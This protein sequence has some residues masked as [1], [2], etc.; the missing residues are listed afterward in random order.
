[1]NIPETQRDLLAYLDRITREIGSSAG[2]RNAIRQE[3]YTTA[4]IAES[5]AVSRNLAS[6]Y[7][8]ELVR[9]GLV[10]KAG[11]R[12][13]HYFHRRALERYFQAKIER[14]AY[15]S[16]SELFS[17]QGRADLLDFS[18][19]IGHEL[20]LSSCIDQLRAAMK[21]PPHGLPVLLLGAPGTGKAMLA[22]LMLEYGRNTGILHP[23]AKLVT[24]DCSRYQNDIHG[25]ADTYRMQGGWAER[26]SGG[27]LYFKD[28]YLLTPSAQELVLNWTEREAGMQRMSQAQAPELPRFVLSTSRDASDATTRA[29]ARRIPMVATV[30]S[31]RDRSQE[32]REELTLHF[33]KEEG[34]RMG[35]DILIS[36]G[37]FRCLASASFE[38]NVRGLRSCVT[39]CCAEAYLE[40]TADKL[41]IRTYQLP[42]EIL[43]ASPLDDQDEADTQ[44]IDTTRSIESQVDDRAA[45][46]LDTMLTSYEGYRA[47]ELDPCSCVAQLLERVRDLEDYLAF[48]QAPTHSKSAAYEHIADSIVSDINDLY[49][50]DLSRKSSH[51]IAQSICL[52]LWPPTSLS[53][54]IS[55]HG[56][57]LV[58][59]LELVAQRRRF[60]AT[61]A[62]RLHEELG[63]VLG[64]E[65]GD[66][67]RLLV[68]AHVSLTQD[69]SRRRR[70]VGIIL[71][72]GYSTATSIADA[73]NR[74]L[75][76]RVFEAI[77]MPYDQRVKDVVGPL[78][79]IIDRFS[80]VDELA[81]LVDMGSL[82]DI[83]KSLGAASS[84]TLGII[85]N[86]STGLAVEVGAGLIDGQPVTQ[87]L[88]KAAEFC[89]CSFHVIERATRQEAIVFCA[90]GGIEASEKI[91]A[92]VAQS[93]EAELPVR[94]V[95][96]EYRQLLN[97][98][99]EDSTFAT[100]DVRA[101]IGTDD[102]HVSGIPFI[103]LE[104]LI[105]GEGAAQLDRAFA[106]LLDAGAL[107]ALHQNLIKNMTLRNVVESITILNPDKLFGEIERAVDRLQQLTGDA[108]SGRVAI[109]L[110]VHLCC[111]VERLVTRSP[112]DSY[113]DENR[114]ATE[115]REFITAFRESF[116]GISAHYRV[117][118]PV[119]EIAYAYDYINSRHAP[120]KHANSGN[121][122][123][124]QQDE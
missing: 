30:P 26:C 97:N 105:S 51:L 112:I 114:F 86:A 14:S 101:I 69:L 113:A 31:L 39:N 117:E 27:V 41:T 52:Q 87:I 17:R 73:A 6:Q 40:R 121:G 36:R 78:Q 72:H 118:A 49:S 23:E 89:T 84:I 47:G 75:H 59:M 119:T 50:I 10:V 53:R 7:L 111:L 88:A 83:Y 79:Q 122:S 103:A 65:L 35:T 8:N 116:S 68:L 25:F 34:R 74:I 110:Y 66:L 18:Q 90:E 124:A 61:V 15:P 2:H 28:A 107:K 12:P 77:D 57:E 20:S 9:A 115:H 45:G 123:Q 32:E 29:L 91:K 63:R 21:Y 108:I 85:N 55:A 58:A 62:A 71:S 48:N 82:Q 43:S 104:D 93:L 109:G 5:L 37:A 95:A 98:G 76:E 120:R 70:S 60:A 56:Q 96:R 54:W 80:Y 24:I 46:I 11:A 102:P 22:Q 106:R 1:M 81:I 16:V 3:N 100:Y 42:P 13:V 67:G 92:L 64:I 99:A 94:L 38:E 19:A 4:A 44:L 33:F